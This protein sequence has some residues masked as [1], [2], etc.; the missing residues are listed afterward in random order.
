MG[1]LHEGLDH[2]DTGKGRATTGWCHVGKE[3]L[4]DG[5]IFGQVGWVVRDPNF[6]PAFIGQVLEVPFEQ[7]LTGVVTAAPIT[8]DQA[9]RRVW[10]VEPPLVVRPIAE[11][12]TGKWAGI[13]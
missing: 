2:A 13:L 11:A 5:L 10:L 9:R 3:P 6:D 1:T 7:V 12:I 8:Q 4:F